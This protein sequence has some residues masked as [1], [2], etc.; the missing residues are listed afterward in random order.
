MPPKDWRKCL[1]QVDR[2]FLNYLIHVGGQ[3]PRSLYG[4]RFLSTDRAQVR[5]GKIPGK[6]FIL[7]LK[8]NP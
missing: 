2:I 7:Y 3:K 5:I 6:F 8:R 4:V 1:Q